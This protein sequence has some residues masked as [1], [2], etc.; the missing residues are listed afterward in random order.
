MVK[1]LL[2]FLIS[3]VP[4]AATPADQSYE[5]FMTEVDEGYEYY[6]VI[7]NTNNDS[8][9]ITIVKGIYNDNPC[10]GI[11]FTSIEENKYHLSI[12]AD[13]GYYKLEKTGRGESGIAIISS[14]K[15]YV[16]LV[17]EDN[18]KMNLK[19]L[20]LFTKT[21]FENEMSSD[22][23]DIIKG[24]GN[25]RTFA[26]LTID[27]QTG[28]FTKLFITVL[29]III[30]SSALLIAILFIFKKGLFNKAKRSENVINMRNVLFEETK[31]NPNND[32]IKES[33]VSKEAKVETVSDIKA[34]L[35]EKG[36]ITN[37]NIL[38][39]EEKNRI[40]LELIKLKNEKRIT[41]D[42][43]YEETSELWKK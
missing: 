21:Q 8:Y 10:Y 20:P 4:L 13:G 17:N 36:F 38:S 30:G 42:K 11:N 3:I 27:P 32:Y 26:K 41:E 31:D 35:L 9:S 19:E 1:L 25:G 33:T 22:E 43:Y 39:E 29:L 6:K 23:H 14:S 2:T 7:E 15:I 28:S 18:K 37:Y 24:Q 5:Q 16:D 12:Y 34:Y 40:M